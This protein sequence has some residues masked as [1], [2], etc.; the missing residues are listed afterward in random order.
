MK[1]ITKWLKSKI[2]RK[3]NS[4]MDACIIQNINFANMVEEEKYVFNR[5]IDQNILQRIY[6]IKQK[7]E[8]YDKTKKPGSNFT[9]VESDD[10]L[11]MNTHCRNIW[12]NFFKKKAFDFDKVFS[13]EEIERDNS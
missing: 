1:N 12:T 6:E 13:S 11:E 4:E 8:F 2:S 7:T 10:L 3:I 9:P 5:D